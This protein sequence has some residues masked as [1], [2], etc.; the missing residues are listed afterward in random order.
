MKKLLGRWLAVG[1]CWLGGAG[2]FA[3][4]PKVTVTAK[5]AVWEITSAPLE[6]SAW[7]ALTKIAESGQADVRVE[8]DLRA[9]AAWLQFAP[10]YAIDRFTEAELK[11]EP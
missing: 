5:D 2:A 1:A 8:G 7:S 10:E 3:Q 4:A 11:R 9:Q 6:A